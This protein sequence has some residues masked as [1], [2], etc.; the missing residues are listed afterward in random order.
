MPTN[1]P[2]MHPVQ[3]RNFFRFPLKGL[4]GALLIVNQAFFLSPF[5]LAQSVSSA[6]E[7]YKL[8]TGQTLYI[9]ED[10]SQPIVTIDTWVKTG[11]VNENK[12]I[13][14]VSHFLEHLLFKGTDQYKPGVID[15]MLEARGSRFN[16]ATSDDFTH[17]YITMA[18]PYFEETLKL[19]AN[20]M[21]N[22]A[23]PNSELPQERKVVQEEINRAN[24]NPDRQLY[25]ELAKLMY[26]Q[27][28]Y[29]Y[30]TL[31][32]KENIANIPRKS[33]LEYYHYWYQP[34]NFNTI[35]VGDVD[36]EK[37]KQLVTQ[38][39]PKPPFQSPKGYKAPSVE[40]V[41]PPEAPQTKVIENPSISQ[42]YFALGFLGP[43]Q[44]KPE[45]VY[46]LDIAMLALGSGKSSRLYQALREVKPLATS[47]S[48]GNYTQ[49]YSGLIVIN[50]ESKPE[51]REA[52]KQEILSQ[53]RT[54]KEKG[55]TPEE[56]LKAKTQYIKDFVFEN[57]STNGTASSIGYNVTIGSL[58]NYLD[59]VSN[60]EKV[61]LEKVETALNQYLN[62]DQAVLVELLPSSLKANLK[63]EDETNLALL[64]AADQKPATVSQTP[65]ST[66]EAPVAVEKI[67]LANG[68]VLLSKP[69]KD[70]ATVALKLFVK[71]GQGVE[72]I[73]G[74]A[75]LVSTLMM[76][77]TQSRTAEALSQELESKGMNL[78]VSTDEDFIEITGTAIQE[79]LG[80]LFAI[81]KDVLNN[82][83]FAPDEIAKKKEQIRQSIA[84]SRDNPS[85]LAFENLSM[86]LYPNHPYGNTGKRI[87][88]NLDQITRQDLL[89]Y[90]HLYFS[91]QNMVVSAV[92]NFDSQTLQNYLNSLYPA[93]SNCER[94]VI[95]TPAVPAL[96]QSKTVSEQKPQL[97]AT[98]IAQGWLVPPIRDEKDYVALKVLNSL[99]GTGMS[100]R[101]FVDLREK[102]GL[103][104]VVGTMYPTR[105][106]QSRFV[107]Y[108][109]TDPGNTS[110]VQNGFSQE[111]KRLQKEP[112]TSTEL[113]E[114][115]SKLIGSF[116]LAHDSNVNQAY[117][118]GLY[119]II[120]AGYQFDDQYTKLIE[121]ITP[122]DI[123]QVA[124]TYF[125]GPSVTSLVQP[126]KDSAPQKGK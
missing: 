14:G 80:E 115:K 28:G 102:Q 86:A 42:A 96:T 92:G 65:K 84:A 76:Q 97:S 93:C 15:R 41:T 106:E 29:S 74:T 82:P 94:S 73:P 56:L 48:S 62:F 125:S 58:Q 83:D 25:V 78:S 122:A 118:L 53:L 77:G 72:T 117:Y 52:V 70:S 55:I 26:G 61:T 4:F 119:E 3:P 10:H 40:L 66:T 1:L 9:K 107:A 111:I 44:Q 67:T 16:A 50:A 34:Q 113:S 105:E 2:P 75:T 49:K 32:P 90:Y 59:H 43:A 21:L 101:L 54:L 116:A 123:Q 103:A 104:Y 85:S 126:D 24:D 23:I 11:S 12:K 8:P 91:P 36:P 18:T 6:V 47:V 33:I 45:D 120:G 31:G 81:V 68:M 46:A 109:G 22:A 71:G 38:A 27:H 98:W 69:R 39:F 7:E 57:E 121:K 95:S 124:Q 114:A 87:E 30:D 88:A 51:N 79:D 13:N 110:K 35:I 17:Y 5:S 19:H 37:A 112:V 99:L 63:T 89:D 60:V 64:K 108:I 100:S 20:M